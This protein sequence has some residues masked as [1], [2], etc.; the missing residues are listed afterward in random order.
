M[1][2]RARLDVPVPVWKAVTGWIARIRRR[3]GA[4][5]WQRA[6]SVHAQVVLVLR[7]L[8]HRVDLHTLAREAG[9]S[10]ATAYRY[11]HESLEEIAAH[12]PDLHEV[13]EKAHGTGVPFLCLDDTLV[14]TDRVA[15][16]AEAGHDLWYSGKH[17]RHGGTVQVLADPGG[18][19]LW[20]SAVRPG[21]VHDLT[22]ARELALPALYPHAARGLPVLA[23]KGYTGAGLGVHVPVHHQPEGPLHVDNRCYNQLIT[24]LRAPTE[25][26]NALLGR[27]RALD[28]V[29]LCPQRISATAA[30]ALVLTSLDRGMR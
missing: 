15:A 16:R 21:S 4:R 6:A 3:P 13:I 23:D 8:R 25:R 27:W 28:R 20:V 2:H 9:I 22:A 14:P 5:P 11:L 19:P 24:A 29:T 12:A 30:A 7:W 1:S 10:D 26:S 18:F 17:P